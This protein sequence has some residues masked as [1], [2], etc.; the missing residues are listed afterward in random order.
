[1][2]QDI[3][4]ALAA[5]APA[6]HSTPQ[7][8]GLMQ[9]FPPRPQGQVLFERDQLLAPPWN[10]W[11]FSHMRELLPTAQ[12][13]RGPGPV[14]ALPGSAAAV[15]P[16][17]RLALEQIRYTDLLGRPADCAQMVREAY[18]DGLLILHRGRVLHEQYEGEL[19]PERPHL[20]MSIT[21][22]LVAMVACS[23]EAQGLLDLDRSAAHYV[24]EL[25]CSA[26]A[27]ASLRQ[28]LEMTVAVAYS[29]DYNDPQAEVWRHAYAGRM[30]PRPANY[31]GPLGFYASLQTMRKQGVHGQAFAYKTVNT[32]VLAWVLARVSG[33]RCAELL[34]QQI[35]QPMGAE[36]DADF[37]LDDYGAEAGGGGLCTSLRD[38]ARF[39]ELMRCA[40]SSAGRQVIAAAVVDEVRKGGDRSLFANAPYTLIESGSYH[41]HWWLTHNAHGAYMAR[42]IFGQNLYIDPTAEL[43]VARYAAHPLAA[44]RY[45]DPLTLPGLHALAQALLPS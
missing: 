16:P 42:G 12:V 38:L 45:T 35:W 26:W 5:L 17:P 39:G 41:H 43:V 24:P 1:M 13:W 36:F 10:R 25:A 2:R 40:G 23:L 44:S 30:R 19:R 14:S 28:I 29:E 18:T 21:K 31:Q 8:L 32:E 22:S 6:E 3:E 37:L 20:C 15:S 7:K 11:T 4:C 33:M 9:G 27:D 34:S